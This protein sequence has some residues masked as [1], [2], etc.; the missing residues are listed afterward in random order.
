MAHRPP[1]FLDTCVPIYAAGKE[2]C[3]KEPAARLLLAVAE[4]T[5]EAVSDVEVIQEI[6]YR[7]AAIRQ[8]EAGIRL[9]EEFL[10]IIER[11]LPIGRKE[12]VRS[13]EIQRAYPSL[14]PRDALHVAVM[15]EAGIETIVTA[16]K[17]FDQVREVR[18]VDLTEVE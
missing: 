10:T 13:L 1:Y 5:I 4:G 14:P 9:A 6:T 7:F 16:D 18:R 2:H 15:L 3:Y 17:H 8:R 12:I 11:L